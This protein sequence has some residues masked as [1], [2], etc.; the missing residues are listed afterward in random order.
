MKFS[1]CGLGCKV[2]TYEA[3]SIASSL[4]KRGC[5]RVAFEEPA[6]VSLIFTC[7]VTN[8]AAQKSRQMMHR[9]RRLNP[10]AVVAMVGCYA[11]V[12]PQEMADADLIIGTAHKQ[13]IPDILE[14]YHKEQGPLVLVDEV[15][16]QKFAPL[17][18][19][20]FEH[21]T[22][23]YLK[24]QDGCNQ[25]CSYCVIPYARGRER[26]LDPE[27]ACQEAVRLSA[28]HREIVLAG[29]HTGRYG[30]EYGISLAGLLKRMLAAAPEIQRFRISSIEVTEVDDELLELM[31][32]DR[33]IA[34]HLHIPLQ[35]GCD[36]VLARMNRPYNTAQY[37]DRIKAVRE[38][39]P[40]VSISC[41]LITGFP[42]EREEDF[43][44]GYEFLKKCGF[45][46]LHVF[47]FSLREGT[48]AETMPDQVPAD[49]RHRRARQCIGLSDEL[50]DAYKDRWIGKTAEVL[51][52]TE[53]DGETFGHSSQ[54][55]PVHISGH[56]PH[57]EI[58]KVRIRE[59]RGHEL[60]AERGGQE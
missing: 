27:T 9:V 12:R 31:Q 32:N 56:C 29:I 16:A 40:D 18:T 54:Y 58:T 3:E 25:F 41:D 20:Q 7:A 6:D 45:S 21:Q 24:I 28:H 55:L 23:A 35:A 30:R 38:R 42:G 59:R 39:I 53:A 37:Y 15:P 4:E 17:L 48:K 19:D 50:Y 2:N 14:T 52:E 33:R 11:Q 36:S 5:E 43:E 44:A 60:Y 26:S 1:I 22:R 13:E 51:A 8:T 49:I 57:G 46:F 10:Q 34:R 47:P